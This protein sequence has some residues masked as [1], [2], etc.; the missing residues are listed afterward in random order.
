MSE[1][2]I[3]CAGKGMLICIKW[4]SSKDV[5]V[6]IS[7]TYEYVTLHGKRYLGVSKLSLLR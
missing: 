7:E 2:G 6:V 4:L 5:H 1:R 3:E